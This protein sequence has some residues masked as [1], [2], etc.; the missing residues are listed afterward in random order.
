MGTPIFPNLGKHCS[1]DVCRHIDFLPFTC[2]C[3]QQ[4]YRQNGVEGDGVPPVEDGGG[5]SGAVVEGGDG[6]GRRGR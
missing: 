6:D 4:V 2:D 5:G 1:V 3:C